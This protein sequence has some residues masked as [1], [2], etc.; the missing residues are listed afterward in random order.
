MWEKTGGAAS[1]AELTF[2]DGG[3]LVTACTLGER[4]C[5]SWNTSRK[6]FGHPA[7]AGR[8]SQG[9]AAAGI[10]RASISTKLSDMADVLSPHNPLDSGADEIYPT[11]QDQ[12]A[13]RAQRIDLRWTRDHHGGLSESASVSLSGTARAQEREMFHLAWCMWG[14]RIPMGSV[15]RTFFST[16]G[17]LHAAAESGAD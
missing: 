15:L 9:I 4:N 12:R 3:V 5:L 6:V 17:V 16:A 7:R 14:H 1:R 2:L 10:V 11:G 13:W 8:S